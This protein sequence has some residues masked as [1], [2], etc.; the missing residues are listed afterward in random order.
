[1]AFTY[2]IEGLLV[3]GEINARL[4]GANLTRFRLNYRPPAH[5]LLL[6]G[7]SHGPAAIGHDVRLPDKSRRKLGMQVPLKRRTKS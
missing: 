5:Q 2:L 6:H 7:A 1:M 3:Q 4:S